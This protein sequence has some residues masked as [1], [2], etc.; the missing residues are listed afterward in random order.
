MGFQTAWNGLIDFVF[1]PNEI[2][3][4]NGSFF[5]VIGGGT[6][7]ELDFRLLYKIYL[8]VPHL[9][10]VI[11]KRSSMFANGRL[12]VKKRGSDD[13]TP[14]ENHPLQKIL[15]KPNG[16]QSQKEWMFMIQAYKCISG[17]AFIYKNIFIGDKL[18]NLQALTPLD[19]E[20]MHI[21]TKR[22]VLPFEALTPADY[23]DNIRFT[24]KEG[25]RTFKSSGPIGY[26]DLETL[27]H[28]HDTGI[29]FTEAYSRIQTLKDP[30]LI[31][32][33]ALQSRKTMIK[34]KG[35]IGAL[36]G[37]QNKMVN[38][39]DVNVPMTKKEK[40]L[41]QNQ[42][43]GFGLGENKNPI[44]VTDTPLKWQP[45]VF[46]SREL[47]LLEET[48]DAFHEICDGYDIRREIFEGQSNYSNKEH[49]ERGTYQDCIIPEWNDFVMKLNTD[50]K[51]A[52]E[53]IEICVDYSH[54]SILQENEK[55]ET[56][57][58]KTKSDTHIA[59][60]KSNLITREEYR[61]FMGYEGPPPPEVE[62]EEST[63]TEPT[64]EE[65]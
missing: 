20:S 56:A 39:N 53:G 30:I 12:Y 33:E 60:L 13:N 49:A 44:I 51:T 18:R 19:Y 22:N 40:E 34:R 58:N 52:D 26:N 55:E 21:T 5:Y 46:S 32:Y 23:I 16:F 11:D 24:F 29:K 6:E 31:C 37:A 64:I 63:V 14:L 43:E 2:Q 65:S 25:T 47:M 61:E 36:T 15:D 41:I 45:F 42:L 62:L 48:A 28:F 7:Q 9:R 17:D 3:K 8:K 27:I 54:I 38:G 50:L 1:Q 35:G 59:E 57:T 4:L 10:A